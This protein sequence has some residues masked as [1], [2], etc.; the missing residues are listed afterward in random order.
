MAESVAGPA[1]GRQPVPG[2]VELDQPQGRLGSGW[3]TR[4]ARVAQPMRRRAALTTATSAAGG[5]APSEA[6]DVGLC[7][8]HVRS[9]CQGL[10]PTVELAVSLAASCIM[11]LMIVLGGEA[12]AQIPPSVPATPTDPDPERTRVATD[13]LSLRFLEVNVPGSVTLPCWLSDGPND[14]VELCRR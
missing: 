12:L 1:I 3:A 6:F 8:H 11:A 5:S 10:H 14:V 13:A 7:G 2:G 4:V 9:R